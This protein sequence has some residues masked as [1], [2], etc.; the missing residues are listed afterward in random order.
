VY[1]RLL[2]PLLL[3]IV[4]AG[5]DAKHPPNPKPRQSAQVP[6]I[7]AFD[8]ANTGDVTGRV[9]WEGDVPQVPPYR[10]PA[11]PLSE[12]SPRRGMRD[13]PNPCAPAIDPCGGVGQAVVLLRG[14]DPHR[15]KPWDL[16]PVRVELADYEIRVHQGDAVGRC[17]L[18]RRG[19]FVDFVSNQS[20]FH[21]L[22]ARGAAWFALPFPAPNVLS[23][24][25]LGHGG[26]IELSSGAGYY[27]MRGY[28][29]VLD[30]PYATLTDAQGHFKLAKIPAGQYELVVWHPNWHEAGHSRDADTCQICRLT[31]Q[32][33]LE[34]VRKIEVASRETRAVQIMLSE[35]FFDKLPEK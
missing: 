13:W 2:P 11:N 6:E 23:R 1:R 4:L 25:P 26:L 20:V 30:H 10:S 34:V 21:S 9:V 27:W 24:R 19:D 35:R 14:V 18:V 16:P 17:G 31:L 29:H 5:C 3:G 32:P 15:A 12:A 28:L 7:T 22:Q 33:P 8:P